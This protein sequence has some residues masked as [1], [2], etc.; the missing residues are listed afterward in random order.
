[1][2]DLPGLPSIFADGAD[3]PVERW[4][5]IRFGSDLD[6]I[7]RLIEEKPRDKCVAALVEQVRAGLP[8]RRFLAAIFLAAIRARGGHQV[9]LVHAAHQVS[10]DLRFEERLLPLFWAVDH[11]KWA[12]EDG[13][14]TPIEELAGPF[15]AAEKAG[16]EFNEVMRR[17]DFDKA[18]RALIVLARG[19]GARQALEQVWQ[20]GCRDVSLIGHRAISVSNCSRILETLAWQHAEPVL[21]YMLFSLFY[22]KGGQDEYYQPNLTRVDQVVAKAARRLGWR[23]A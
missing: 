23:Q 6:P 5:G 9:F 7:V 20:Y 19:E 11:Y 10:L 15:P 14:V 8:Y 2:V 22:G 1:L 17:F 3:A 4:K 13:Q 12:Y 21:G 16:A 18:E